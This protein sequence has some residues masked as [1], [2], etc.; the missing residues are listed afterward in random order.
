M[1]TTIKSVKVS[2]FDRVESG[3]SVCSPLK[4]FRIFES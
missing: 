4:L 1:K 3:K 2:N